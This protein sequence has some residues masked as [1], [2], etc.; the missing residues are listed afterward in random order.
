MSRVSPK[1]ISLCTVHLSKYTVQAA[2][3]CY[4]GAKFFWEPNGLGP[5]FFWDWNFFETQFLF[6][7][8]FWDP[9]F[10]KTKNLQ[11]KIFMGQKFLGSN[12][13]GVQKWTQIFCDSNFFP[14]K[15]FQ[16]LKNFWIK[17]FCDSN[18]SWPK[19]FRNQ[20]FCA[21]SFLGQIISC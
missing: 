16:A 11:N 13:F 9:N 12:I 21:Q 17:I 7:P 8:K 19:I 14:P 15:F 3:Q 20:N 6:R 4:M 1:T 18:F 10:F 2:V 5:K